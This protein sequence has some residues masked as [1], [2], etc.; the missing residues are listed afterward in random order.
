MSS[1]RLDRDLPEDLTDDLLAFGDTLAH[2]VGE[3]V[4]PSFDAETELEAG[5]VTVPLTMEVSRTNRAVWLAAAALMLVAAGFGLGRLWPA[6]DG[7]IDSTGPTD[8]GETVPDTGDA[9]GSDERDPSTDPDPDADTEDSTASTPPPDTPSTITAVDG[10]VLAIVDDVDTLAARTPV[11]D[12]PLVDQGD[13]VARAVLLELVRLGIFDLEG[14][15]AIAERLVSEGLVITTTYD[16]AAEALAASAIAELHPEGDRTDEVAV[17]TI[18]NR[19]GAIVA[20]ASSEPTSVLIDGLR[21]PGSTFKPMVL[22]TLFEQG[23]HPDDLVDGSGPCSF[24]LSE[25]QDA[26]QGGPYIVAGQPETGLRSLRAVTL[27]SNNCAF[28]RL[29][30]AA[31]LD[32]VVSI[33]EELGISTLPPQAG[34][35][36]SFPLG[37]TEVNGVEL[38][39]AY[40]TFVNGG[41]HRSPWL[42]AE[43]SDRDGEVLYRRDQADNEGRAVLSAETAAMMTAVLEDNI[44]SGTGT[45]ARLSGDHRAAGKTGTTGDFVDA[46]FVGSTARYT[47]VVWVGD[48]DSTAT[49]IR[50]PDWTS[51]GGALPAA[52]WGRY[53]DELHRGL[54]PEP[55]PDATPLEDREPTT[56]VADNE[57]PA[58]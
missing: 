32:Q 49:P 3:P 44:T 21:Q 35:F 22:A 41:V 36:L 40:A 25:G 37:V 53:N 27:S 14:G 38:A 20:T 52:V 6:G 58:E 47:T 4:R 26:T 48:P 28:V 56:L 16:P 18:D 31:G 39:S 50:M 10:T 24:D 9:D 15:A 57:I 42:V 1:D 5:P 11:N 13:V 55:F 51:F 12:P 45:R 33:T 34:D 46:W 43:V 2:H 23:F 54:E 30:I 8:A 19:T 7:S 17:L 29:G